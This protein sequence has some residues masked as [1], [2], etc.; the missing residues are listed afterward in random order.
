MQGHLQP[1]AVGRAMGRAVQ[2]MGKPC[3]PAW[4]GVPRPRTFSSHLV[5]L[6]VTLLL[7]QD[8]PSLPKPLPTGSVRLPCAG[9][10]AAWLPMGARSAGAE[11]TG[12]T[13]QGLASAGLGTGGAMASGTA[14]TAVSRGPAPRLAEAQPLA[15]PQSSHSRITRHGTTEGSGR[16]NAPCRGNTPPLPMLP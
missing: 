7:P 14:G 13:W 6:H 3:P 12:G 9:P 16:R 11:P 4:R 15:G 5:P 10:R 1:G 8:P 2:R